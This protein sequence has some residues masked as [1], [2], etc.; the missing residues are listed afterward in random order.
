M[1][2]FFWTQMKVKITSDTIKKTLNLP[3][4]NKKQFTFSF[5]AFVALKKKV[6]R[7]KKQRNEKEVSRW[8]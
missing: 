7:C 4:D 8:F 6:V 2:L 5:C 3:T 1:C